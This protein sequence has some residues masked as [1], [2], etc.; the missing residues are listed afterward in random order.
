MATSIREKAWKNF[1]DNKA[2]LEGKQNIF[3]KKG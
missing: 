1:L 2:K 3:V